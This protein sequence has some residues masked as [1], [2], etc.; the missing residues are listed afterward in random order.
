MNTAIRRYD[1]SYA[2]FLFCGIGAFWF[3]L[4]SPPSGREALLPLGLTLLF[5][6]LFVVGGFVA[7]LVGV[8]G[9]FMLW[10][11]WPLP[12]LAVLTAVYLY[13]EAS[14]ANSRSFSDS[15]VSATRWLYVAL[16]AGLSLWWF[17]LDR[18]RRLRSASPGDSRAA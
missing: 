14:Y 11:H 12:A 1:R 6:L 10:R 7:L 16:T 3:A 18:P 17:V 2:S 5:G 8:G 9:A 4:T 13:I 15:L